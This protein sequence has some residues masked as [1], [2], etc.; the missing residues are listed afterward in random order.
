MNAGAFL[1]NDAAMVGMKNRMEEFR[2]LFEVVKHCH[3]WT[4]AAHYTQACG[5]LG[6]TRQ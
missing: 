1:G 5:L 3:A 4:F 2:Q 6:E